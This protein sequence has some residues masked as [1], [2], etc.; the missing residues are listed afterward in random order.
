VFFERL[1][2]AICDVATW[3]I[4]ARV[5]LSWVNPNP[6]NEILRM[7]FRVTEPLLR[8][9]RPLIPVRGIDLSPILALLLIQLLRR[10]VIGL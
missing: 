6:A 7:V 8:I 3:L 2:L 5:V 10:L 1:L 9:L 4:I